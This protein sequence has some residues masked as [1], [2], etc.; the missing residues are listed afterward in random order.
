[1]GE[2]NLVKVLIAM[3]VAV[4]CGSVGD[5]FLKIGME[6]IGPVSFRGVKELFYTGVAIF[7]S[8]TIIIGIACLAGFF[9]LWLT[10]LSWADLSFVLPLT[11]MSY[12]ATPILC[13]IFLDE[14]ITPLRWTGIVI[15]C[16]GVLIVTRSGY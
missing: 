10:L 3:A 9:F 8:P 13:L 15:I 4:L 16:I 7:K 1:M 12:V 6:K 11:A 2:S 14:I 5:I